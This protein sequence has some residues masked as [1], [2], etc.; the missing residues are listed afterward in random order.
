MQID[1]EPDRALFPIESRWFD[2]AGPR[3]HYVDEGKG[4]AVVLFHGNPTWSFLYR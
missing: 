1:F 3:I 4:R 2:G